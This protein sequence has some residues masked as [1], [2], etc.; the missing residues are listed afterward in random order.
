VKLLYEAPNLLDSTTYLDSWRV[1]YQPFPEGVAVSA[2]AQDTLEA[3]DVVRFSAKYRHTIGNVGDSML[4][5]IFV[6]TGAGAVLDTIKTIAV[7]RAGSDTSYV[8]TL[9][10]TQLTTPSE[11]V[12]EAEF[13][14]GQLPE[15]NYL[16]NSVFSSVVLTKD[17]GIYAGYFEIDGT[18]PE[19]GM[20][21]SK[22]P[23]V[24]YNLTQPFEDRQIVLL[25]GKVCDTCNILPTTA[26]VK[27]GNKA[28]MILQDLETGLYEVRATVQ[29]RFRL[30]VPE[31]SVFFE[32]VSKDTLTLFRTYPNPARDNVNFVYQCAAAF[33][34]GDLELKVYNS[35]GKEVYTTNASHAGLIAGSLSWDLRQNAQLLE[36]GVYLA[37]MR[38]Y[39][40]DRVGA[41]SGT[42][43]RSVRVVVLK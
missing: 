39:T 22:S 11:L 40:K 18:V 27:E 2:T 8:T 7:R 33:G 38:I 12:F 5:N 23:E 9:W 35:F 17:T 10:Q 3:G 6:R 31:Q 1:L 28:R 41:S 29:D 21:T 15:R 16:N 32:V 43:A 13:N 36:P 42:I 20:F 34:G 25:F 19:Y 37:Q 4:T 24:V 30:L 14:V 26:Y